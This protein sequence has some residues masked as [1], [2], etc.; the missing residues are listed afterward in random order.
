M[1]A[2]GIDPPTPPCDGLF[3]VEYL[4][5]I[6]PIVPAGMGAGSVSWRDIA[7]WQDCTGILLEPWQA[8][9]I[10][11][12][13]SDYLNMSREAEKPECPAP[14]LSDEEIEANRDAVGRKVSNAFKAYMMA[15]GAK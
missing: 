14:W 10:R 8:K 2:E 15:K 1:Q 4:M 13:S 3:L 12:L 5:E 6:G 11:Q 7:A 9:L